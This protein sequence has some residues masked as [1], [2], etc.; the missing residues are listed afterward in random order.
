MKRIIVVEDEYAIRDLITLNLKRSGYDVTGVENAEKALEILNSDAEGFDIA[1]LD[2]ML[3]GINGLQLCELIRRDN[4]K[5]GI[6]M[7]TA[8]TQEQDK[9]AGLAIG[10]DDYVTKPFSIGELIARVDAVYRR[11]QVYK[12]SE[13]D[14]REYNLG[15][16]L[17]DMRS[18]VLTKNGKELDLTQVEFQI[19]ELF[20]ENPGVALDRDRIL[21]AVW[22][23]NYYGDIKIVDVNIRRLRM[24]V[25]EEPSNPKNIL[26]VWGYGY[27]W[28][29]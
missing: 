17:L 8:K 16:F 15:D 13:N 28:N 26:T 12:Q 20:F 6:I 9:I 19:M 5:I 14:V 10:A 22:G 1:L 27:R 4:S 25:E 21:R 2:I 29:S 24:K 7:L 3:P 23:K 11:T 18:R